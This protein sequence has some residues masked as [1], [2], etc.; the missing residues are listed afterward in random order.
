MDYYAPPT[1]SYADP[2]APQQTPSPKRRFSLPSGFNGLESF[3][4]ILMLSVLSFSFVYG[5]AEEAKTQRDNQRAAHIFGVIT[6]L[7]AYYENSSTLLSKRRYPVSTCRNTLNTADY[8]FTLKQHLQGNI[9]TKNTH[10]FLG[11]SEFPTDPWG[12]YSATLE[13]RQT[14]YP[15]TF[16]VGN[17][18]GEPIYP[19]G[20]ESCNFSSS[21]KAKFKKCYLYATNS[22]GD[23]YQISYYSEAVEDFL[24][25]KKV[26]DRPLERI[27]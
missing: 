11:T 22:V 17:D 24:I 15:C 16:V 8:E 20:T 14:P 7:D 6:L 9:P 23:E 10:N 3:V 1:Y 26:Q 13:S 2:Y 21:E 25:F 27:R 5:Y 4:I 12:T 18:P 19:D